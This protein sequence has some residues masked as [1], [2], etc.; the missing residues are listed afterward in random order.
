MAYESIDCIDAGTDYCPCY[1]AETNN[2]LICSQLQGKLFCDCVNWKGVCIYQEYIWNGSRRKEPRENLAVDITA[3]EIINQKVMFLRIK[4]TRT[5]SREL[6]HPGSYI[7]LKDEKYPDFFDVPTSILFSDEINETVDILLQMYGAK[8]KILFDDTSSLIMRGPYWNG[9]IGL[10]NIKSIS[11]RNC[12]ILARGIA[13]APC[14]LVAKKLRLA[15]NNVSVILD[16][17]NSKTNF[18]KKY[19]EDL[20]CSI[21]EME[22]MCNKTINEKA[23]SAI[24]KI[25]SDEDT[26]FVFSGGSDIMHKYIINTITSAPQKVLFACTN[27][28]SICCGEGICGSCG[29]SLKDGR[30]IKACKAQIDPMDIMGGI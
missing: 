7:F 14:V 8:T 22:I 29:T 23:R 30:K 5:L 11:N 2:C 6:N 9:I 20:G 19:F 17:G 25:I 15:G 16:T 21:L 24:L 27:N 10:K 26:A 18:S 12:L 4:V 28:S 1:L 13:Q 3:K